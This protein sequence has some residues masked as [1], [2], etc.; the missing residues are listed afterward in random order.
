[1][2]SSAWA[3]EALALALEGSQADPIDIER[4]RLSPIDLNPRDAS[5]YVA[6]SKHMADAGKKTQAIELCK[7][8]AKIQPDQS[9]IYVNAL[10]YAGDLKTVDSDVSLWAANGLLQREWPAGSKEFHQQA[11]MHLATVMDKLRSEKRDVESA[12]LQSAIATDKPRD[13]TIELLWSGPALLSLKVA[14]PAGTVCSASQPQTTG[15]G[16]LQVADLGQNEDNRSESYT[17]SEAF[18]GGYVVDIDRLYGR[19]TANK[20]TLKIT[21]HAG[22]PLRSTELVT[23]DLSKPSP[24]KIDLKSGRRESLASVTAPSADSAR[25]EAMTEPVSLTSGVRGGALASGNGW[26]MT[27]AAADSSKA[28]PTNP[29]Y[30]GRLGG[31]IGMEM[32]VT[33]KAGSGE[34]TFRPVFQTAT[35]AGGVK[36]S[37]VPG[38]DS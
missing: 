11:K 7:L 31:N 21:R 38:G 34:L 10:A 35:S 30:T 19:P 22:T 8:A 13:L 24:V 28:T 27:K 36:V 33:S 37:V 16:T 20:A 17:V 23:I 5:A 25:M 32:T 1:M 18:T 9:D 4:A 26:S 2:T 15:G 12:K 29:V 14:E 6:A 3:H